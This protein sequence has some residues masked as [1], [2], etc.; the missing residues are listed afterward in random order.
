[1]YTKFL[2]LFSRRSRRVLALGV[3]CI[4]SSFA[5]GIQSVGEVQPVTLIEAGS[6]EQTG[7]VNGDGRLTVEDAIYVLEVS[8]G[9]VSASPRELMADPNKDGQFTVSDAIRILNELPNR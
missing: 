8:E 9:Y 2:N 1:M 7:D 3:V 6:I 5:I 4:A